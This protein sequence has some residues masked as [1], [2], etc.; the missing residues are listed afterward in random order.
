MALPDGLI[1]ALPPADTELAFFMIAACLCFKD[2]ASYLEEWLLFHHLQ[3]IRRFYLYDNESTDDWRPIVEP[4]IRRGLAE[5]ISFPGAG[6]QSAVY[7]DCLQRARGEV[8]WLAFIDDD[9]FLFPVGDEKLSDA[10]HDFRD[11]AGVAVAWVVYGSNG[12]EHAGPEWVLERFP[13]SVGHADNH[14]KCIV[15]P[16]RVIRSVVVGHMFE[17]VPPF[18]IVDERKAP[19]EVPRSPTPSANRLRINHYM[20]KSWSEWRRRRLRP[21]VDTGDIAP[22]SE[23]DWRG[24]DPLNSRVE[25][26]GAQRFIPAMLAL[27][28]TMR[29]EDRPRVTAKN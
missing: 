20:I 22:N 26:R 21:R 12:H 10:L 8:E 16:E 19:L 6:V 14:V 7:D 24:W 29:S 13:R 17:A 3:G 4:W 18:A 2:S 15:R 5:A 1:P 28:E 27:R 11:H 25:D 9:E 23:S